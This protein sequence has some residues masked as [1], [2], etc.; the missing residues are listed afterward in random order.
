MALIYYMM[1]ISQKYI[2]IDAYFRIIISVFFIFPILMVNANEKENDDIDKML[3]V[4]KQEFF[5]QNYKGSITSSYK[6]F[7]LSEKKI[8]S[9]GITLSS[10]AL[11]KALAE[12][13]IY[14]KAL[15]YLEIAEKEPFFLEYINAQVETYRLRGRIYGNLKMYKLSNL[16][17]YKQLKFSY[18]LKDS[19]LKKRAIFWAHQNLAHSF[20][21]TKQH[22]SV[23]SHLISQKKIIE[24]LPIES[25][26]ENYYDISTT[27]ASFA[28]EY[29]RIGNYVAARNN[30][31]QSMA[32]LKSN[33]SS[34]FHHVFKIYGDLE[35][36]MGNTLEA[37]KYYKLA[38]T[39][40]IQLKNKAA[41]E[42]AL[43]VL[44]DYFLEKDLNNTEGKKYILRHRKLSDSL[45]NI[46]N[47]V[48][49]LVLN[50]V[51]N[52]KNEEFTSKTNYYWIGFS[53]FGILSISIFIF[54]WKSNTLK[55]IRLQNFEQQ[56]DNKEI[57]HT[58]FV[59]QNDQIKF[60]ELIEMGKTNNSQFIVLFK[61]L[62]PDFKRK[63]K[64]LDPNIKIS[65]ISF[66]AMIFLNF[67]TKEISDYTFVTI[68]AVQIRKNRLRKKYNIASDEDLSIWM[69]SL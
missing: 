42:V 66:C 15:N 57:L 23:W 21:N 8:Y 61:E 4:S 34:Y 45:N 36:A 62:Y 68:R 69:R 54:L 26:L 44:A 38:L 28:E 2:F 9:K 47:N 29:I 33:K 48:T 53:L 13:G 67:S 52:K 18:Q 22:D 63:L 50:H 46:N 39:N 64:K 56:L 41:E 65:E 51:L 31:N 58:D 27:Y 20:S 60:K 25:L 19:T 24:S 6:V 12:I 10:I 3:D 5:N 7:K 1:K 16:E 35:D 43:K 14:E 32:I 59:K 40:A 37:E 17:F 49:N 55:K 30:L 11:A